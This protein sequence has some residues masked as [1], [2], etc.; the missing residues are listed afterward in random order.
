M[1][2]GHRRDSPA[3]LR[4]LDM[5]VVFCPLGVV[6]LKG[7]LGPDEQLGIVQT[8]LEMHGKV[9]LHPSR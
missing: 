6:L 7:A 1:R 8:L 9:P 3:H 4:G 2:T 5:Q